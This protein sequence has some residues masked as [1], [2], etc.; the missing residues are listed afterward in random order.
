METLY[1]VVIA[2]I[3]TILLYFTFRNKKDGY[4]AIPIMKGCGC[5]GECSCN[6]MNEKVIGGWVTHFLYTRLVAQEIL[7]N[8]TDP[9]RLQEYISR[10]MDNQKDI[11]ELFR[12][13]YGDKVS[14]T[15]TANLQKHISIAGD[16]LKDVSK[17]DEEQLEKDIT[18][19]YK[20]AQ[21]IG[22][23]LDKLFNT[24]DMYTQHMNQHIS[25]LVENV[26]AYSQKDYNADILTLDEYMQSGMNM[27][28]DMARKL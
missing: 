24:G 21:D 18:L 22:T 17:S 7:S 13:K 10:L 14:K 16:V 3:I 4:K 1:M 15:I 9:D 20:N 26:K 2:V 8:H 27:A 23:Y 6:K 19:F 25:T 11:G 28:Y 12:N 5:K